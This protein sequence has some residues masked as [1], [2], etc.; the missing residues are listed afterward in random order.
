MNNEYIFKNNTSVIC[1]APGE[2]ENKMSPSE[3][4]EYIQNRILGCKK[5]LYD[6]VEIKIVDKC[7]HTRHSSFANRIGSRVIDTEI[8]NG[9]CNWVTD[10]FDSTWFIS[11]STFDVRVY[12]YSKKFYKDSGKSW[13][14]D[15]DYIFQI[16]IR[17]REDPFEN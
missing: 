17:N 12:F 6:L 10:K 8:L 15:K 7:T 16:I 5:T 1:G 13:K 14:S 11:E 4:I 9:N 2:L 3:E